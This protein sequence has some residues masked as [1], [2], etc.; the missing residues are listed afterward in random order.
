MMIWWLVTKIN[1]NEKPNEMTDGKRGKAAL[2]SVI[3]VWAIG[4]NRPQI[5][6]LSSPDTTPESGTAT[7]SYF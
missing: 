6:P 5:S 7:L 3:S 4:S 1:T 2:R